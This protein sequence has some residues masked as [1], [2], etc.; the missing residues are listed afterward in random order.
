MDPTINVY[1]SMPLSAL[2]I[3]V[4]VLPLSHA[5]AQVQQTPAYKNLWFR[6]SGWLSSHLPG[7]LWDINLNLVKHLVDEYHVLLL[8]CHWLV[9]EILWL[10]VLTGKLFLIFSLK[11]AGLLVLSAILYTFHWDKYPSFYEWWSSWLQ[12]LTIHSVRKIKAF[13]W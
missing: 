10:L 5:S 11:I 3:R 4:L 8:S 12:L 6:G 9:V 7:A 13:G 2:C 1:E